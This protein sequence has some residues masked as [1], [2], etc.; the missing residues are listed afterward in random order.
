[1]SVRS[2]FTFNVLRKKSVSIKQADTFCNAV[3]DTGYT[4]VFPKPRCREYHP[5][6]QNEGSFLFLVPSICAP[7]VAGIQKIDA[8]YF[9][10]FFKITSPFLKVSTCLCNSIAGTHSGIQYLHRKQFP[11]AQLLLYFF[12][13][14]DNAFPAER[15]KDILNY[16]F[17]HKSHFK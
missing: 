16:N 11:A 12:M 4:S 17:K 8:L 5:V 6:L 9:F 13:A 1:M 14:N 10:A 7:C 15:N 3:A 2:G